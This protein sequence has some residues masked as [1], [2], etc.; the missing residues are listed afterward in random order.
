[1]LLGHDLAV[2]FERETGCAL[3]E[4][5]LLGRSMLIP[6]DDRFGSFGIVVGTLD[7]SVPLQFKTR[8]YGNNVLLVLWG[9]AKERQLDAALKKI[10]RG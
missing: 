2:A 10:V 4:R 1:M 9:K 7:D 3:R 6:E 5:E 8:T